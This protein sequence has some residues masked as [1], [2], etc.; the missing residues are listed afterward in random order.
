MFNTKTSNILMLIRNKTINVYLTD[1]ERF[2]FLTHHYDLGH[3]SCILC[4]V[5]FC[6]EKTTNSFKSS[7]V[8]IYTYNKSKK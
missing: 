6:N 1:F 8:S 4:I 2:K 5:H 3:F 7:N